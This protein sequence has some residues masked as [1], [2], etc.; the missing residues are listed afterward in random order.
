MVLAE[1]GGDT[2]S[3][4]L[5]IIINL[6]MNRTEWSGSLA[7]DAATLKQM[8]DLLPDSAERAVTMAEEGNLLKE[9]GSRSVP[10][11]ILT[12]QLSKDKTQW[13]HE[14]S[15]QRGKFKQI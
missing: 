3:N 10:W 9:F 14:L 15:L 11:R 2:E 8:L 4:A 1:L 5:L 13:P 7:I 12:G 6:I